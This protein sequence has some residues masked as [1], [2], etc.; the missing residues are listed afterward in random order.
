MASRPYRNLRIDQ[1]EQLF[2]ETGENEPH[3]Y[4]ILGELNY[5]STARAIDL[6]RRL[7]KHLKNV[8]PASPNEPAWARPQ[9]P[10]SERSGKAAPLRSEAVHPAAANRAKVLP[11]QAPAA[12]LQEPRA[13]PEPRMI[14]TDEASRDVPPAEAGRPALAP[15]APLHEPRAEP[16]PRMISTDEASRDVPPAEAGRPALSPAQRG[17]SQ[18]LDYVR[19]LIQ[20]SDKAV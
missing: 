2:A 15:A 10:S 20:L 6:K 7:E 3:L 12:L 17:V 18:L 16:E 4:R 9:S 19:D 8:F 5:R 13:E 14:S 11:A 1:L